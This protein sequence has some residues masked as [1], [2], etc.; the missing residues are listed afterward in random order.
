MEHVEPC[1][2]A[3]TATSRYTSTPT[4][5]ENIFGN[6]FFLDKF[7]SKCAGLKEREILHILMCF[8]VSGKFVLKFRKIGSQN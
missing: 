5:N 2:G 4:E 6:D 3:C 1:G 8:P 7:F